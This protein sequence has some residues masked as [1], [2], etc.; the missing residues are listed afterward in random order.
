MG[1]LDLPESISLDSNI[2]IALNDVENGFHKPA[3][4]LLFEIN[5]INPKVCVSILVFE[6]FLVKFYQEKPKESLAYFENFLTGGGRFKVLNVDKSIARKAAQIR[7]KYPKIKTP[8][9]IHLACAIEAG[10]KMF[11]TTDRGLPQ[12]IE[13]LEITNLKDLKLN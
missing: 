4:N 6:E 5:E 11:I 1:R 3:K 7:A 9:A 10:V 8:D 2:F 12:K 13:N